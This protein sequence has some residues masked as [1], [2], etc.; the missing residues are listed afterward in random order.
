MNFDMYIETGE[1]QRQKVVS[2]TLEE[3][4]IQCFL[5]LSDLS[6]LRD[7]L[8]I[9]FLRWC[10]LKKKAEE[11]RKYRRQG[12]LESYGQGG[13]KKKHPPPVGL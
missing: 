1:R 4:M 2:S 5:V 8:C 10:S 6:N 3:R 9:F 7:R 11:K 12:F 13:R